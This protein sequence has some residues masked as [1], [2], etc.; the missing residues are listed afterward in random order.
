MFQVIEVGVCDLCFGRAWGLFWLFF[1]SGAMFGF[2]WGL[3][4]TVLGVVLG[5]L[6][7]YV[8]VGSLCFWF[9]LGAVQLE[10]LKRSPFSAVQA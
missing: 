10:F 1:L 8:L 9:V 6:L 7:L 2:C 4:A 5:L 3:F